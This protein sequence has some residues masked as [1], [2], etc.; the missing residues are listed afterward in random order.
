M[1]PGFVI[2]L[3]L[4]LF[5]CASAQKAQ[6]FHGLQNMQ[7][8]PRNFRKLRGVEFLAKIK[9]KERGLAATPSNICLN[10]SP[11]TNVDGTRAATQPCK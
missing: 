4:A 1:S 11:C 8:N 7:A 5:L 6:D 9:S 3:W 10:P 2:L